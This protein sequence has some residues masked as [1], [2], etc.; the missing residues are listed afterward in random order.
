MPNHNVNSKND[1]VTTW[2]EYF[3]N[4]LSDDAT[5]VYIENLRAEVET[6]A[7]WKETKAKAN[8]ELADIPISILDILVERFAFFIKQLPTGHGVGHL[9]RD[10]INFSL[11][12]QDPYIQQ[13]S[14]VEIFVALIAGVFHDIGNSVIERYDE[15]SRFTGHAEVGAYLFGQIASDIIPPNLLKLIQFA[16]SSHTNYLKD[17]TIIKDESTPQERKRI[18]RQYDNTLHK[19]KNDTHKIA[20]WMTQASDRTDALGVPFIVRL[21]LTKAVPTRDYSNGEFHVTADTQEADFMHQFMPMVRTTEYKQQLLT[22]KDKTSII[23]EHFYTYYETTINV[24]PYSQDDTPYFSTNV[25]TDNA[26]DTARFIIA[27]TA[28]AETYATRKREKQFEKFYK[29]CT[30]LEPASNNE[31]TVQLLKHKFTWLSES[32]QNHWAYGFML[33]TDTLYPRWYQET[34]DKLQNIPTVKDKKLSTIVA[35]LHKK[36]QHVVK[37]FSPLQ[38]ENKY[39]ESCFELLVNTKK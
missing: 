25:A 20:V 26:F 36:A 39:H 29:L 21:I 8:K 15:Q 23:L 24:S 11:I 18:R 38:M 28:K 37:A 1:E 12:L 16:I 32:Y 35:S 33:L 3:K 19:D 6:L 34:Y 10:L 13:Q 27:T 14:D 22:K 4:D 30:I 5:F 2:R 9:S 7:Q 17:L 31:K